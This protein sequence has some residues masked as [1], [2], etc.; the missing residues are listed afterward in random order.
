M[1]RDCHG[2]IQRKY[3]DSCVKNCDE[4]ESCY[5]ETMR[6]INSEIVQNEGGGH[7]F[8]TSKQ[9]RGLRKSKGKMRKGGKKREIHK[10][11]KT[12]KRE[13]INV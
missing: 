3:T 12:N 9:Q 4:W 1:T 5:R 6:R 10:N 7:V 8:L 13:S 2:D 11:Y